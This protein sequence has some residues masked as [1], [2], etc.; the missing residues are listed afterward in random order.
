MAVD[1]SRYGS[2]LGT[3]LPVTGIRQRLSGLLALAAGLGAG[4]FVAAAG[5]RRSPVLAVAD[6][7]V[8][9]SP[10]WIVRRAIDLF[11]TADKVVLIATIVVI[12]V[13]AA[14]A[15]LRAAALGR[16]RIA[17]A[18]TLAVGALGAYLATSGRQGSG[19]DIAPIAAA[20]AV[21]AA[22]VLVAGRRPGRVRTP[23]GAPAAGAPLGER[24]AEEPVGPEADAAVLQTIPLPERPPVTILGRRQLLV[25]GA[26]AVG[27]GLGGRLLSTSRTTV[28]RSTIALP[29]PRSVTGTAPVGAPPLPGVSSFITPNERFYRIDTALLVPQVDHRTWKLRI[30]GAVRKP[31]VLTYDDLLRRPHIEHVATMLCVSNEIGGDLIGTAR[32]QGVLLRDLLEEAGVEPGGTQVFS[33]SVDGWTCGFPTELA[34]DGRNAMVAIGMNGEPLPVRHGFPARLI[35]PGLYGYVSSTKWLARIELN[36]WATNDGYWMPRGWSKEGPVKP[37]SRIDTPRRGTVVQPGRVGVGGVAWAN[38]RGVDAVQVRVD[39]GDWQ[40]A[41][42]HEGVNDDSW[43]QWTWAW[44][45]A[46]RGGHQLEVRMRTRDGEWQTGESAE[47]APN[48]ATGWHSVFVNVA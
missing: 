25:A 13:L 12:L 11:G 8:D 27:G 45:D 19:A 14:P 30:D 22:F 4:Q 31:L 15:V 41:T 28:E 20:T 37:G 40:D 9:R 7:V 44:N 33:T 32:W 3:L 6:T 1:G 29:Q 5:D 24:P 17:L 2:P 48:G 38:H 43:R 18:A 47:V 26:I 23:G 21:F 10:E 34:L 36:D 46:A 35:V 42:L 39:E 16:R